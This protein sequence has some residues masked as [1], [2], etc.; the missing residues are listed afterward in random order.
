MLDDSD[1]CIYGES[2]KGGEIGRHVSYEKLTPPMLLNPLS[3]QITISQMSS[4]RKRSEVFSSILR[5][6]D[7]VLNKIRER[8]SILT[9]LISRSIL[10]DAVTLV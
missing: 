6:S 2:C 3:L 1:Y 5:I 8:P 4:F 7:T 9:D 10:D